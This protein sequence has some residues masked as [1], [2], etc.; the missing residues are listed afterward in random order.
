MSEVG[1]VVLK[2]VFLN[3]LKF[4]LLESFLINLFM[5]L[6]CVGLGSM[7]FMVMVVLVVNL[8]NLCERFSSVVFVML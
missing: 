8:V 6:E 4:W 2:K 3:V 5:F 1:W 7:V